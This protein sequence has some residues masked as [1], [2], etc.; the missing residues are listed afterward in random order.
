MPVTHEEVRLERA[1]EEPSGG[2]LVDEVEIGDV[3]PAAGGSVP[4][5]RG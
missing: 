2:T 5:D 4:L 3:A 1:D